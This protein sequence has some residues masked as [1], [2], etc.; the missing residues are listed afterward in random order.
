MS[1]SAAN[2]PLLPTSVVGSYAKPSWFWTAMDAVR[3]GE[4]GPTDIRET[5]EDATN[6]A[7]RDQERAGVDVI[8]DG[9]MQR[10][11]FIMGFFDRL[12]GL[13][14]I[15]P[16]RRQG[17]A[18]YDQMSSF[19]A[20]DELS[21][22]T[23]LG[24]VQEVEYA[25][26]RTTRPIKV[27]CPGPLT[28]SFRI[29]PGDAYKDS[30]DMALTM[31][32]IVNSE[33]R[34]LVAAGASFIQID[35]PRYAN[36]PGG[37]RQWSDLFNET[38]KE[39]DAKLALHI[40]FGN[41]QNRPASRRSYRPMFP[42]ILDIKADQLVLEFAN[43]EMSEI[44]LWK[45]FPSDKELGAGV[46]DIKSYYIEKPQEV[47]ERVRYILQYVAPE[48]LWV[49]PDCGFNHTPRWVAEAK[50]HAMVEGTLMVRHELEGSR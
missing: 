32:R 36:F 43:R 15:E 5:L 41:Y 40:C 47:A 29:D 23:G 14:A 44:D 35:E 42:S 30:E 17:S 6:I 19:V 21:A 8:S 49:N 13:K 12:E 2:L 34:A 38:V 18:G 26:I 9:E 16:V 27:T 28:L 3:R 22:P 50:L 25:T 31:V 46:I 33:L 39:V 45:E 1:Q 7:I 20:V 48:K 10:Q 11:D 24:I 37:G 4:Y